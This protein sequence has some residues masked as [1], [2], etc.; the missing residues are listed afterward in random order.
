MPVP[1]VPSPVF[2]KKG[3]VASAHPLAS[4]IGL[5]CLEDGG[6]AADAAVAMA[7]ATGVLLPEMSGIG[8]DAFCL[9]YDAATQKVTSFGGSGLS[10]AKATPAF[11]REKGYTDHRMPID[12][13]LA[14]SVPGAVRLYETLHKTHGKLSWA[15]LI[16]PSIRL[17]AEGFAMDRRYQ[18]T[19]RQHHA[20][21]TQTE[22]R[23]VLLQLGTDPELGALYIQSDLAKSLTILQ[24][25][26]AE[27][28]YTGRLAQM[29]LQ[30]YKD[31]VE[32]YFDVATWASQETVIEEPIVVDY[33]GFSVFQTPPPSQGAILL[34]M[35]NLLEA[36]SLGDAPYLSAE[37][38]HLMVEAKKCAYEDRQAYLAD[39]NLHANPLATLLSK[40]YAASRRQ[41]IRLDRANNEMAPGEVDGNTTSFVAMDAAGNG[42]SF[43]HSVSSTWGSRV[44]V[45]GTGFV[46]NNRAGRGF[47][48]QEG[49]IN[50]V[51]PHKKTMH[52]LNTY[53]VTENNQLR[54]LGNT[55]GGDGQPQW[56]LQNLSAILDHKQ[57]VAEAAASPRWTSTPGT[58]P[59]TWGQPFKLRLEEGLAPE[60]IQQLKVLGHQ[61]TEESSA[62]GT[63]EL[64][65]IDRRGVRQGTSDPRGIGQAL[66]QA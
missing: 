54:L 8:G 9:Y 15:R 41:A 48:L 62:G 39:P 65:Y 55:P 10:S 42:V 24:N 57:N 53:L 11:F 16:D 25:E 35:L 51:A 1:I 60:T 63:V 26:G 29:I 64:I 45:Q 21:L 17:A 43:I 13:P 32:T 66:A 19:I 31:E 33:H 7:W 27:A 36:Y 12:G 44:M 3:M 28:L 34:E 20:K 59:D 47:N 61:V 30:Y 22:A 37:N 40:G 52:T 58:D 5:A 18:R 4:S 49:H 6:S 38:I 46:L 14:V 56:N 2:G 23:R 50:I